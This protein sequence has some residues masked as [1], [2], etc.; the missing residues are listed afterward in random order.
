MTGLDIIVLVHSCCCWCACPVAVFLGDGCP[1]GVSQL[2][3]CMARC[4]ES[5]MVVAFASC[6]IF[7]LLLACMLSCLT[8]LSIRE[9]C[10]FVHSSIH[11]HIFTC[12]FVHTFV[13]TS[14]HDHLFT[15]TSL[16]M[17]RLFFCSRTCP[18]ACT[19][20]FHLIRHHAMFVCVPI[21]VVSHDET[22]SNP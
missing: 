19:P 15:S 16:C 5:S 1:H 12:S 4:A 17:H 10:M 14:L 9:K 8:S 21:S 2:H 20:F 11:E 3:L 13:N 7:T 6:C 18:S 22:T